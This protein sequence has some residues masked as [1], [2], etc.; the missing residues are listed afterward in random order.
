MRSKGIE[1][2]DVTWNTLITGYARAQD[3][4]GTFDA[5]REAERS[6]YLWNR[7]TEDGVK[8]LRDRGRVAREMERREALRQGRDL[9]FSDDIIAGL[10]EKL[11]VNEGGAVEVEEGEPR[12]QYRY[13]PNAGFAD[14]DG[15]IAE[16]P[17]SS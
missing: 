7:W 11:S 6:G 13:V 17:T 1:P 16:E 2:N 8:W 10:G 5:L 3:V 14:S 4:E 15:D 12:D 9:D